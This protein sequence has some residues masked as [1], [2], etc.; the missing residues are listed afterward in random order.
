MGDTW[1]STR[2]HEGSSGVHGGSTEAHVGDTGVHGGGVMG[3]MG[4]VLGHIGGVLEYMGGD[5]GT[6]VTCGEHW[7]AW[8][9]TE[10]HVGDTGVH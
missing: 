10:A 2:A 5:T 3:Y 1:R 7:G 9:S 8:G 4:G 6:H